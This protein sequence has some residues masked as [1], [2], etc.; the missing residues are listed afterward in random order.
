MNNDLMGKNEN[1]I[2]NARMQTRTYINAKH[3]IH[4]RNIENLLNVDYK[5]WYLEIE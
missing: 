1:E 4:A 3:V 2:S 5:P